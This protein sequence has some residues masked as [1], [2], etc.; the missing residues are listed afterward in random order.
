MFLEVH[1]IRLPHFI[2]LLLLLLVVL[3]YAKLKKIKLY[4]ETKKESTQLF[5]AH[6]CLNYTFM[7]TGRGRQTFGRE[8]SWKIETLS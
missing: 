4:K 2:L 3:L 5:R 8:D 1:F 7:T 6:S